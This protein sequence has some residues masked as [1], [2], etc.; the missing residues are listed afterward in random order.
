MIS[1]VQHGLKSGEISKWRMLF[2]WVGQ[3]LMITQISRQMA[4]QKLAKLV[5]NA[6]HLFVVSDILSSLHF[7]SMG[8]L[9][10]IFLRKVL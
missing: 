5:S 7:L 2:G 10:W 8:L 4:S 6:I 3:V 1:F 9:H